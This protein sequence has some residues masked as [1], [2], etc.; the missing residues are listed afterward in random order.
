MGPRGWRPT[1]P[2]VCDPQG[3]RP[4]PPR[5]VRP[6]HDRVFA[7]VC[8]GIAR[9]LNVPAW[10][11]RGIWV[12]VVL[13]AG[14]GILAYIAFAVLTPEED[15]YGDVVSSRA[16]KPALILVGVLAVIVVLAAITLVAA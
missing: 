6:Y 4:D 11:L 3:V 2:G 16:I 12:L 10:V 5:L 15:A 1:R 13:A 9:Q 14:F 7:G 8:A